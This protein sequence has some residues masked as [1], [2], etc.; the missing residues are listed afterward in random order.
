MEN[1]P[2]IRSCTVEFENGVERSTSI[3]YFV[4]CALSDDEATVYDEDTGG[5]VTQISD[6]EVPDEVEA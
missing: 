4:E 3:R 5:E 1:R 6:V 2:D